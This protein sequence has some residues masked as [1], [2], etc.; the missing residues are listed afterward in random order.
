MSVLQPL[1]S[2]VIEIRQ[3]KI[4]DVDLMPSLSDIP[5][6]PSLLV[7]SIDPLRGMQPLLPQGIELLGGF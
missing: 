2:F 1:R 7:D 6:R 3:C 5:R 4:P